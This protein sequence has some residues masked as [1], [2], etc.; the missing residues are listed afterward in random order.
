M[1]QG[2][3]I[4]VFGASGGIGSDLCRTLAKRG[5][6]LV[7]AART[8]QPLEALAEELDDATTLECDATDFE[9]VAAVFEH[10]AERGTVVGAANLVGSIL[11]KP[12]HQTSRDEFDRTIGLNLVSAFAV[13]RSAAKAMR[14]G[15]S[16]VL[17]GSSAGQIGVTNHEAIAAAKAG[18]AGLT[19]SA[20]ATYAPR[21]RVNCVAPGL[22]DTPLARGLTSSEPALEASK[23]MHPMGRIGATGDVVPVLAWLLSDE[24]SW[25]TG[26]TIS[27]DGGMATVKPKV[28][29]SAKAN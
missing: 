18:V 3:V 7:L 24:S 11:L 16:I 21:I 8:M 27:V 29:V 15:G 2:R 22:V 26:Q 20:A 4:V 9:Q 19:R 10:A 23:A 12:A 1:P 28:K 5:N 13:V 25:V 17:M 14:E 6:S